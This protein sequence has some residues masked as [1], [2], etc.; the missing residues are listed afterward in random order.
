[1]PTPVANDVYEKQP[2]LTYRYPFV[3]PAPLKSLQQAPVWLLFIVFTA[4]CTRVLDAQLC[5]ASWLTLFYSQHSR[6][7]SFL[8]FLFVTSKTN[9]PIWPVVLFK[10]SF[11]ILHSSVCDQH[12]GLVTQASLTGVSELQAEWKSISYLST[13]P[14]C[15]TAAHLFMMGR[16]PTSSCKSHAVFRKSSA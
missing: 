1:M 5:P 3:I 6:V 2:A 13:G 16:I 14:F 11:I 7:A 9:L 10:H 4:G 15:V 8:P 12:D